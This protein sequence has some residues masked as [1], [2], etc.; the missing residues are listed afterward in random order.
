MLVVRILVCDIADEY[1]LLPIPSL[2]VSA[3]EIHQ[4]FAGLVEDAVD[5]LFRYVADA[6]VLGPTNPIRARSDI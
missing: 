3:S 1:S 6:F 5:V 2:E 4:V